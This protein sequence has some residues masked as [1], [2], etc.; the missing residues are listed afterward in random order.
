MPNA[1]Q[2]AGALSEPT[3][4]APLHTNRMITGLWT[5]RSFMRDAATNDYQEKYGM[6]RQDSILYGYNSEISPRLT[7]YRRPGSSVYNSNTIAPVKRFYSFN[8]FTLTDEAIKVLAD[9][10]T[11]VLDITAGAHTSIFHKSS[12]AG[13]T[14]FLGVGNVLYMTNGVDNKQWIYNPSTGTGTIVNWGINAPT[15]APT[16]AIDPALTYGTWQPNTVFPRAD[17][18]HSIVIIDPNGNLQEVWNFTGDGKTGVASSLTWGTAFHS[19]TTDGNVTWRNIGPGTWLSG[20]G[21]LA[22]DVVYQ[23]ASDGN[24]YFFMAQ[25]SG[26]S[27]TSAPN[28]NPAIQSLTTDGGVTWKNIGRTMQRSDIGNGTTVVGTQQIEDPVTTTV[29]VVRQAGKSGTT[30]PDFNTIKTGYTYDPATRDIGGI[31]WQTTGAA[32]V[33]QYGYA[34]MNSATKDI[35]NMSPPSAQL[36]SADGTT[37]IVQGA[38]S[39]DPQVDTVIVYRTEH[40]GST[41]FYDGQLPN[42]TGTGTWTYTDV[43]LDANLN[44]LWQAQRIGEGTP[45]PAGASCL[46]YHLGRIFAAVGNVVWISSG[47]DAVVGGSSG[48]AGFDTTFTA[49]SKVIRFWA[50]P[51]GMVVFTVRDAY[52]ILG[53]GTD[54]D[55]LYMVVFIED[56]PLRS[57][58]CFTVNKTTPYLLLGN[59]TLVAL[60]PSA[61]ITEIGFPIADRLEEEF[62]S[63]ASYV[64]FHKQSS[65]DTALYVA[66][67][68]DHWY[69]MAA[70]SAPETGSN[71]SPRAN[72]SSLGCVQSVEVSPGTYRLLMS[73]T[74]SGP[75]LQ[76]ERT[77]HSD[78]GVTYPAMTR[79]GAIV[80]ALPGQLAALSFITLESVKLGTRPTLALL[81]GEL[82][83][84][85][86]TLNRTHQDPPDLPPSNT[87]FSDRYHFAQNQN[88]AWCRHFQMEISWPAED[89]SNELLTYTIFGQ[90]W[91]EMRAQ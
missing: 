69:R 86:E 76:R 51:L 73:R 47:P 34:Y 22:N 50:C 32:G 55:P 43:V 7:L 56:L 89:V 19:L 68:T 61:G 24:T 78:N 23:T 90:T 85:F 27:G 71:W 16:A 77:V 65:R 20:G 45:L 6:G 2:Q 79:F 70:T 15:T 9:T 13:S 29:Q 41:F 40:G 74:S 28:W 81:L 54:A 52:I 57:Y 25:N 91:Q 82:D 14:Y 75:I 84:E 46:G 60:D 59:N 35:S 11:D 48:N 17:D 72:F 63:S 53:S 62:D 37:V 31:I 44:P 30:Q 10:A 3:N 64:T 36:I 5:N 26:T 1:L 80:L 12:G 21:H 38:Y 66:N 42:V 58:D 8:T 4:F 49:Q 83:G 39:S 18:F 33:V 88:T 67:G 87:I